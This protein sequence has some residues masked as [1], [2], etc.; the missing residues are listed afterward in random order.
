MPCDSGSAEVYA[1]LIPGTEAYKAR[2]LRELN[3]QTRKDRADQSALEER[4]HQETL[5]AIRE[6]HTPK[7]R[8]DG[9]FTV[10]TNVSSMEALEI[11][12]AYAQGFCT[13]CHTLA[14][15]NK[16]ELKRLI[17]TDGQFAKIFRQ[18]QEVDRR[19]GRAVIDI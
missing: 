7:V 19:A 13:L 16:A 4:R 10:N 17:Q 11:A 3:E 14:R 12:D 2:K 6:G 15:T 8:L 9:Q 1:D 5:A 18:H